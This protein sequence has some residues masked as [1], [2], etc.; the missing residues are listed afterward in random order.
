MALWRGCNRGVAWGARAAALVA[1]FAA[2]DSPP[3]PVPLLAVPE[4]LEVE[5]LNPDRPA[6]LRCNPEIRLGRKVPIEVLESLSRGL[7]EREA[8]DCRFGFAAY[9]LPAMR[10][11]TGAWAIAE[12]GPETSVSILGLSAA[13]EERLLQRAAAHD[14]VFG[15]WVD[16]TSYA[17]V[18]S[19]YRDG[20]G[21]KLTRWYLDG[22]QSTEPMQIA[23]NGQVFELRDNGAGGGQRH[24][25]LG[26]EGDLESWDGGGFLNAARKV[27]VDVDLAKLASEEAERRA[28]RTSAASAGRSR[29]RA[30]AA[31]ER[32][33]KFQEWLEHYRALDPARHPVLYL[34]ALQDVSEREA[35]CERF[36][37]ALGDAPAKLRAEP[38]PQIDAAPLLA[39]LDRLRQ[40]CADGLEIKVVLESAAVNETWRKLDRSVEQVVSELRPEED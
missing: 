16:D 26:A 30:A 18:V 15:V 19:L 39:A 33:R 38:A 22:G 37:Q 3:P 7:L 35:A 28:R 4:G 34:A 20:G 24:Y 11:G 9:Y 32:W 12:L 25:R 27:R 14:E 17:S 8:K 1:C 10:P 23:N 29:Q 13:D 6:A 5:V 2:C 36:N 21:L 40:A 31:E